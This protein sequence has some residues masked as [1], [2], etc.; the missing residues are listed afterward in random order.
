ML[1]CVFDMLLP[2]TAH[3]PKHSAHPR[4]HG[5]LRPL[6]HITSISCPEL[7]GM[8]PQRQ[9]SESLSICSLADLPQGCTAMHMPA[10]YVLILLQGQSCCGFKNVLLIWWPGNA[11]CTE[12][13]AM[14]GLD[15]LPSACRIRS[16]PTAN[17][18]SQSAD[19]ACQCDCVY[20]CQHWGFIWDLQEDNC[21]SS[22]RKALTCPH[23]VSSL[24]YYCC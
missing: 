13:A 18:T 1:F 20:P 24:P 4:K 11:V 23:A 6:G 16:D 17:A 7:V 8:P 5:C 22:A 19:T 15:L 2:L 9:V 21:Q 3:T 14:T 10:A 12:L